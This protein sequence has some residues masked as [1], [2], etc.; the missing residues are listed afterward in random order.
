MIKNVQPCHAYRRDFDG[1]TC[2]GQGYVQELQGAFR[3]VRPT[4]LPHPQKLLVD[5]PL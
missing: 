1:V 5:T 4:S 3:V 2:V